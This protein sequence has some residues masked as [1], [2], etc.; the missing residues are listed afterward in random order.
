MDQIKMNPAYIRMITLLLS[1]F[2][3][4]HLVS[5]FYYI[6]VSF[7]DFPPGCWIVTHGLIDSDNFTQ[8]IS[9]MYW[10]FQTLTT[11]GYGDM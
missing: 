2:F 1:V 10:A 4:V 8:Y 5:C 3:L 11:V 7:N 9:A 6:V